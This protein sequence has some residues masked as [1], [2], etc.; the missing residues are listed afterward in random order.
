MKTAVPISPKHS[1]IRVAFLATD[2]REHYRDYRAPAPY[3]NPG[4]EALIQ[5]FTEL[6]AVEIHILS[7]TRQPMHS[8]EKLTKNVWYHSVLAPKIGWLSTLYQG[9]IRATRAKLKAIQPDIV[10]GYGTE[11]DCA[12]CALF[13]GFPNVVSI[14]GNLAELARLSAARVGSYDW[15][16]ARLEDFTLRRTSGVIANSLYTENLVQPRAQKTWVVYPALRP[17]F[18]APVPTVAA[19]RRST[20]LLNVGVI[21]P[22]KR[23]LEL[24]GVAEAL[25]RRGLKFEFHFIGRADDSAY[26]VDFLQR[27]KPLEATGHA[28]YLGRVPS[29]DLIRIYDSADG[30]IHFSSEEAFGLNVAEGLARNLKFFGARLG[31]IVDIAQGAP[32]AELFEREDWAGLTEA[33]ARWITEGHPRP[34]DAADLMRQRYAPEAVARQHLEIY[35]EVI[36][37]KLGSGK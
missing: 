7:C 17:E 22:R 12:I 29:E 3:F 27:I 11:R 6:S 15:L 1:S 2:T 36:E 23:Q 21:S 20:I 8:P 10:H 4:V 5:G 28:R 35:R 31:G 18:L 24:L 16:T 33:I 19:G 13:S 37:A 25:Q 34:K 26:A 32:S 9:C 14:Q 30:M